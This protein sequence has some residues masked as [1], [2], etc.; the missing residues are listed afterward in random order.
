[1]NFIT[2]AT[3]IS[4][5]HS[6]NTDDLGVP[7]V[8]DVPIVLKQGD[9]LPSGQRIFQFYTGNHFQKYVIL[10][11]WED[12]GDERCPRFAAYRLVHHSTLVNRY[13]L[14]QD[15]TEHPVFP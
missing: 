14:C 1:M 15:V 7:I 12:W 4:F 11:D 2:F 6:I 8:I 10:L 9:A 5:D 13:E 3:Q